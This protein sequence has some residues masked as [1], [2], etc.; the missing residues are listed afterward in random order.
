MTV[1][2]N[3]ELTAQLKHAQRVAMDDTAN[4]LDSIIQQQ[5]LT[6]AAD[7]PNV[8]NVKDTKQEVIEAMVSMAIAASED[9]LEGARALFS[10]DIIRHM[11]I[12]FSIFPR[13]KYD[14]SIFTCR[15]VMN[16][17]SHL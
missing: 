3:E 6:I 5:K 2:Q 10:V 12:Y 14:C 9:G 8:G 7:A 16:Y 17:F 11:V 13:A 1:S 4:A 15:I